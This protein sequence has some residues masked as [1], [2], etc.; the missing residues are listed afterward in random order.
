ML[1]S[2]KLRNYFTHEKKLYVITVSCMR[3]HKRVIQILV[4]FAFHFSRKKDFLK[5]KMRS[6]TIVVSADLLEVFAVFLPF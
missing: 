2:L 6:T 5:Y 3:K 4:F 1:L